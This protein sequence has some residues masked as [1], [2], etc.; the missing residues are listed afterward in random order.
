MRILP[1]FAAVGMKYVLIILV[2]TYSPLLTASFGQTEIQ[3]KGKVF[4]E[5][6]YPLPNSIVLNKRTKRGSF[7]SPNGEFNVQCLVNDTITITALGYHSRTFT[8]PEVGPE[9]IFQRDVYLDLR[10]FE[11]PV[12]EIFGPRDLED[13]Q[14]DIERL[15]YNE[16]DYMLS[17]INAAANP[18][19]FLYQQFS[20][21]E[22]SKREVAYLVNEDRK[23]DL[24]K[25]LFRHYV[26][27]EIIQ[28]DNSQFDDFI[29]YL[30]V[31]DEFM[32]NST[33]Y[34]FLIYVR[35]RFREYK[36]RLRQLNKMKGSDFDYDK[37]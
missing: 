37:D 24:L 1:T 22:Q 21:K 20:K 33:Q 18:I 9:N 34:D 10:V 2:L 28:L 26:D 35:D 5:N 29:D 25:E 31:S 13:I 19:T 8:I 23:R 7:G 27:Y 15:G 16:N 4:D 36:V 11:M 32:R 14:E 12:V 6:G 30:N 17:G 3:V